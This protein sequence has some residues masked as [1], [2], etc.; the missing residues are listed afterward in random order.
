MHKALLERKTNEGDDVM[1]GPPMPNNLRAHERA[2][3]RVIAHVRR[4]VR[5]AWLHLALRPFSRFGVG[6]AAHLV[7][8]TESDR[9]VDAIFERT[10]VPSHVIAVRDAAFFRWRF[11]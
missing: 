11:A 3:S 9:H 1:F 10:V 6:R 4:Y 2:G 8:F 5:P 7:P